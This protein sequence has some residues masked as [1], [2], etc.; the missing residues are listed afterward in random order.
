M[1]NRSGKIRQQARQHLR[2]LRRQRLSKLRKE[3]QEPAA[4]LLESLH[5]H[6]GD[7]AGEA[8]Q[9]DNGSDL[10]IL[11]EGSDLDI[12]Q[13][14][15]EEKTS[16]SAFD[17]DALLDAPSR[18]VEFLA[19]A[20]AGAIAQADPSSAATP[21]EGDS[22][23]DEESDAAQDRQS[24]LYTLPGAGPGLVWLLEMHGVMSLADLSQQDASALRA[25]LG[26]VGRLFD[27]SEWID[28]AADHC[29]DTGSK[30]CA[31]TSL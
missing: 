4:D 6:G 10:E 5:G 8:G 1:S 2:E 22:L 26:L 12:N 28:F 16:E 14:G 19:D 24:D 25:E 27:V 29:R 21:E 30:A 15:L 23:E 9:L 20:G 18:P 11:D 31:G 13:Y 7:L 17:E 3:T